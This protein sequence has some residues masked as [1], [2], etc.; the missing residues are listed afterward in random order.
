[1]RRNNERLLEEHITEFMEEAKSHI[2]DCEVIFLHAP[3]INKN[4]FMSESRPLA[5]QGH[6]IKSLS[7]ANKKANVQEA[8]D[9][10]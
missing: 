3:G 4:F 10:I 9:L 5:E 7:F 2:K 1:M 6:K 8:N